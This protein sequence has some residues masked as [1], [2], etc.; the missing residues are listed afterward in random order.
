MHPGHPPD[1]FSGACSRGAGG[2][3]Q[4]GRQ[5]ALLDFLSCAGAEM[6]FTRIRVNGCATLAA[7][8]HNPPSTPLPGIVQTKCAMLAG[9]GAQG[10]CQMRWCILP[11]SNITIEAAEVFWVAPVLGADNSVCPISMR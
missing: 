4:L 8:T 5:T 1:P 10:A 2:T 9:R 6:A 3:G 11:L 7:L